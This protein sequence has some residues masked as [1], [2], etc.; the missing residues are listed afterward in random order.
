MLTL[1]ANDFSLV[2]PNSSAVESEVSEH[3]ESAPQSPRVST[4]SN[5][6]PMITR[7]QFEATCGQAWF[8]AKKYGT[9]V[10]ALYDNE[11]KYS[12]NN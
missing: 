1:Q 12:R 9:W 8:S 3:D 10:S 4:K 11:N 7:A 2:W 5:L 6:E